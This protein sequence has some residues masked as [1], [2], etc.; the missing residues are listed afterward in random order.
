[1]AE[2]IEMAEEIAQVRGDVKPPKKIKNQSKD[3]DMLGFGPKMNVAMNILLGF[4][5]IIC[6]FPFIYIIIISFSSEASIATEGFR[7]IPKEWSTEAYEYL[8]KMKG[9]LLQS[10]GITIIVTVLG[11][12]M[13]VA[14]ISLYAY[15]ISR[16]QFAYRRQFTFIA[17]FTMLFS[18]GM[19]PAYI[20]MTQFLHLRDTIW[21]LILPLAMNAFYIMIMRTFFIRSIPEPILEAARI[22]GAGEM[23]IFLRIVLPLSLPGLATIALFSTLGYWNDWFQASLYIDNPNLVPLQSLL[24]KI[25]NNLEFMRQNSE[26]AYSSGALNSIPQ[27]GAKMAMVVISTLPI[28]VTY[29]FFQKYFISGLTIGG[30]KE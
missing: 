17:F 25:E 1:M 20:V 2:P 7:L 26:I 23:R 3:R 5:A 29:P 15:A 10:Y 28:A 18:G 12:V 13:S 19:V 16:P 9:Q 24:M 6:V 8:W 14:M 22:E 11:T 30:V 4:L 27:D 21:A